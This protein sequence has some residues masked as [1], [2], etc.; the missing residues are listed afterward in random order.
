VN[1]FARVAIAGALVFAAMAPLQ[2]FAYTQAD[3]DACTA[4]AFR[5]CSSA[6]PDANRVAVC[7][8]QNK[9]QLSPACAVVFSRARGASANGE[10]ATTVRSTNF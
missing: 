4:D 6:I 1:K 2:T 10:Q 7:L 3:A 5:L 9:R 8:A